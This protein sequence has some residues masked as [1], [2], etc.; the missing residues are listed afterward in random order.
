MGTQ[1]PN[2]ILHITTILSIFMLYENVHIHT[3][4]CVY[5]YLC[6]SVNFTVYILTINVLQHI[7]KF[8]PISC[9]PH[10]FLFTK[11]PRQWW[12]DTRA[13]PCP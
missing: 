11:L 8:G 9:N 4:T 6:S 12:Y 2:L 10:T 3:L 13:G 1:Y 5:R 7:I